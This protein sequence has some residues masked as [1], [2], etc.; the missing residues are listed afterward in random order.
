MEGYSREDRKPGAQLESRNDLR[1]QIWE[2]L[3]VEVGK[4]LKTSWRLPGSQGQE[5]AKLY[6]WT[7]L[8]LGTAH[9]C[10]SH[11]GSE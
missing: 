9:I 10:S 4:Y 7:G 8:N 6:I 5:E 1:L 2:A 11:S 3:E